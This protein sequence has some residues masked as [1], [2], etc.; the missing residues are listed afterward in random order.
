MT[1]PLCCLGVQVRPLQV[2]VQGF[3][4]LAWSDRTAQ[5]EVESK[6]WHRDDCTGTRCVGESSGPRGRL[7]DVLFDGLDAFRTNG[8]HFCRSG[9]SRCESEACAG[10]DLSSTCESWA[11]VGRV[12]VSSGGLDQLDLPRLAM[13]TRSL[14]ALAEPGAERRSGLILLGRRRA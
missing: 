14:P 6:R 2:M 8:F 10:T 12:W 4:R 3:R 1:V 7:S 9:L 5:Y 11:T 13:E